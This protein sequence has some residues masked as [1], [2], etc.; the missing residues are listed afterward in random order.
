MHRSRTRSGQGGR[1]A[2]F[3]GRAREIGRQPFVQW[4]RLGLAARIDSM[5]CL[6]VIGT[7]LLANFAGAPWAAADVPIPPGE[8]RFKLNIGTIVARPETT[9]RLDGQA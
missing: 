9:L 3:F 2:P 7:C 8:E 5:R 1:G 4:C 6:K